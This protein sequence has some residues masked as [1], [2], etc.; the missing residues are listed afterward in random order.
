VRIRR[1]AVKL[2]NL[3]SFLAGTDKSLIIQPSD[4]ADNQFERCDLIWWNRLQIN[5]V[6]KHEDVIDSKSFMQ[7]QPLKARGNR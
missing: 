2:V 6:A 5:C 7:M 4:L 3:F 1:V